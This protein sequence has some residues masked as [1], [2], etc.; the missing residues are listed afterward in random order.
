MFTTTPIYLD[1]IRNDPLRLTS[2]TVRFFWQSRRLDQF[3]GENM[4][5]TGSPYNSFWRGKIIIDNAG[6]LDLLKQ[7]TESSLEVVEYEE[8]THSVQLDASE[9]LVRSMGEWLK[10]ER[11]WSTPRTSAEDY[12]QSGREPMSLAGPD[13]FRWQAGGAP[14]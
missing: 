14:L 3:I 10:R 12:N 2:A 13:R 11:R 7:G 6:V 9:R 1:Y 4:A 5:A 8:Q